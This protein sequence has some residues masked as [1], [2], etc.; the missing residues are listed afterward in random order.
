MI[1]HICFDMDGT[2][3]NLYEVNNW[4]N[5]LRNKDYSVY[6]DAAPMCDMTKVNELLTALRNNGIE[7]RVISWA[8]KD[9][10]SADELNAIEAVKREWLN[11]MGFNYDELYTIPYGTDKTLYSR[12]ELEAGETAILID[13]DKRVRAEWDIGVAINP[14]EIKIENI[15]KIILDNLLKV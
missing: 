13:D 1:K 8:S 12:F 4:L 5:R 14:I 6:A 15:L 2:I 11:K 7:I 9:A 3:A 10:H